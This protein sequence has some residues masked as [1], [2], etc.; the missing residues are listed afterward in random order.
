MEA[1]TIFHAKILDDPAIIHFL[2][3][4]QA[5][6][7]EKYGDEVFLPWT[8]QQFSNCDRIDII[9]DQ[10]VAGSLKDSTREKRGKGIW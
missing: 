8:N 6:T 1:S 7:F 2:S 9:W 4:K 10:Y 5:S 3:T